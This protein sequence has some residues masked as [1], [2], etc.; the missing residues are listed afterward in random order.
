[1][2]KTAEV[3]ASQAQGTALERVLLA[4]ETA[5]TKVREAN[6]AL[7]TIAVAVKEALKEDK[8]RRAEIDSVR[9]GL[10]K[11]QTIKV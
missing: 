4:Y 10:A 8:Q 2:T 11:L 6:D 1:M 5:K 3:P 9:S 7:A